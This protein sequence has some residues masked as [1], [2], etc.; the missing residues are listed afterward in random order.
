MELV[1][2]TKPNPQQM[3]FDTQPIIFS[4]PVKLSQQTNLFDL[5]QKKILKKRLKF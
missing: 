3:T 4:T 2:L 5:T 1:N